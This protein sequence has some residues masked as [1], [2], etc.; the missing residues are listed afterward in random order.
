MKLYFVTEPVQMAELMRYIPLG[1]LIVNT[2]HAGEFFHAYFLSPADLFH[3]NLKKNYF[4]NINYHQS[5]KQF[6][7]RSE[8][9]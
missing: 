4:R 8:Q 7:S 5:V 9:T 2:L 1:S 6:G 3:L